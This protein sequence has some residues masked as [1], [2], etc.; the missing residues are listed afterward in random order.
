MFLIQILSGM[1]FAILTNVAILFFQDL[2][3]GEPGLATT[4]FSN[5][6]NVGNLVGYFSFGML[7][8]AL[9]HRGVCLVSAALTAG[10]LLLL[11]R[12]RPRGAAPQAA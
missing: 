4:I 6:G 12:W 9:G 1:S 7:V 3:P 11:L 5:A 8:D 10:T 2:L